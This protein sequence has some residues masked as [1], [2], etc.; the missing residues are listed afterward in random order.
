MPVQLRLKFLASPSFEETIYQN[1]LIDFNLECYKR[2]LLLIKFKNRLKYLLI[3]SEIWNKA[4]ENVQEYLKDN[5]S[6]LWYHGFA[7]KTKRMFRLIF[8]SFENFKKRPARHLELC[9]DVVSFNI[10]NGTTVKVQTTTCN[11][12][13]F[14]IKC[15][16]YTMK[17]PIFF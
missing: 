14:A 8:K 4:V 3:T 17:N 15:R 10:L 9:F 1:N 16:A 12:I 2:N 13:T 5:Y 6:Q 7:S 11:I